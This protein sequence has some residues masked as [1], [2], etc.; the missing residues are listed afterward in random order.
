MQTSNFKT[1]SLAGLMAA[2][3]LSMS[4]CREESPIDFKVELTN[5]NSVRFD[6]TLKR[7]YGLGIEGSFEVGKYGTI[8][9]IP[10]TTDKGF[11]LGF[12]LKTSSFLRASWAQYGEVTSLPTGAPFPPYMPGPLVEVKIPNLNSPSVDWNFYFGVRGQY[13]VGVLAQIKEI[14]KDFPQ[15]DLGYTFYDKQ[16]RVV[17]GLKFVAPKVENG[18]VV[19]RGGIL[20]GTNLTPFLSRDFKP[21][22]QFQKEL[23]SVSSR[24][25]SEASHVIAS[26]EYEMVVE[27]ES[28][29]GDYAY[30]DVGG[31]DASRARSRRSIQNVFEKYVKASQ[32]AKR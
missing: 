2:M 32:A 20:V 14:G 25:M 30:V 29:S 11:G 8:H 16:G 22:E 24:V 12:D 3:T 9:L 21:A 23:D 19:T 18:A 27:Q 4:G 6:A 13:V 7:K 28:G 1:W 5:L 10:E 31:R 26:P 15:V 17:L